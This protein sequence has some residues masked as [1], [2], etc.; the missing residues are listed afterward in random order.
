MLERAVT[1]W[2]RR[3]V[4]TDPAARA[5]VAGKRPAV[6]VT[7]ASR[8]IGLAIAREFAE[9]GC[10]LAIAARQRDALDEAAAS[11]SA[12]CNVKAVPIA[13][14]VSEASA[15]QVIQTAL[16]TSGLYCDVLVNNAGVGLAGPFVSHDSD[17]IDAVL[18]LNIVALT[19]LTRAFLPAML[20]RGS[21]GVLNVASLGGIVPGPNQA[22]YYASK[23]YVLSLSEALAA[24][25]S[26][27]GVRITAVVP[28]PVATDFHAAMGAE[29]SLYRGL[30]PAL[31]PERIAKSA[32]RGWRMGRRVI[33]P[34]ILATAGIYGLRVLPH[35]ITVPLVRR[36]L[37][38]PRGGKPGS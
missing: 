6:V 2:M 9:A 11:I 36:L 32:V 30:I 4:I 28:G 22:A 21:G 15:A 34:G 5:A 3:S 23:A 24:E 26:G 12:S 31:S 7:G 14:D 16:D 29:H 37:A 27:Q 8:G 1:A 35:T 19:R 33:G 17:S 10:D 38:I 20:A 18:E 13:V 25:T